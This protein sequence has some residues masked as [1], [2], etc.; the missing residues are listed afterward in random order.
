MRHALAAIALLLAERGPARPR[1][2]A[3]RG[4]AAFRRR[5]AGRPPAAGRRRLRARLRR[6]GRRPRGAVREPRERHLRAGRRGL[7]RN[8]RRLGRDRLPD[9]RPAAR[10]RPAGARAV[11]AGPARRHAAPGAGRARRRGR[12]RHLA[13]RPQAEER[14][15]AGAGGARVPAL[16]HRPGDARGGRRRLSLP[17]CPHDRREPPRHRGRARRGLRGGRRLLAAPGPAGPRQSPLPHAGRGCGGPDRRRRHRHRDDPRPD[18]PAGDGRD[19]GRGATEDR[20][21]LALRR[22]AGLC[23]PP[24]RRHAAPARRRRRRAAGAGGPCVAAGVRS[25][26]SSPT[27]PGCSTGSTCPSTGPWRTTAS[28][29]T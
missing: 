24:A 29:G 25:T 27:R 15:A 20:P 17:L 7:P 22:D 6:A 19:A 23:R 14:R 18:R 8:G 11:L 1:R 4:A 5:R 26:S 16:R 2:G 10:G 12:D 3:A 13:R 28:A 9:A 21:V